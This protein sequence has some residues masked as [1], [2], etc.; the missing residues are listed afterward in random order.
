MTVLARRRWQASCRNFSASARLICASRTS[1]NLPTRTSSTPSKPRWESDR[2]MAFPWGSSTPFFSVTKM[3]AFTPYLL[4]CP[5]SQITWHSNTAASA[6]AALHSLTVLSKYASVARLAGA[7]HR[8]SRCSAYLR[9]GTLA[10]CPVEDRIDV[11]QVIPDVEQLVE[12]LPAEQR[13][14]LAVLPQQGG[15]LLVFPPCLHRGLLDDF[16]RPF[17]R[18][19][20]GGERQEHPLGIDEPA[21]A[22]EVLLH[23]VRIDQERLHHPPEPV[24]GEV[25]HDGGVRRDHPLRGRVTDVPLVPEG[26]V[27]HRGDGI[28]PQEPRQP[29]KVLRKHGVA[30]VRH[31][32]GSLLSRRKEFL[33]LQDL[34]PLKV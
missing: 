9:D 10:E 2:W 32:G 18:E 12:F 14:D 20:L 4:Q 3:R 26:D 33:D 27:F 29:G 31:R 6:P 30:L 16:I 13:P 23:P 21:R 17:P 11:F 7:A 34:R 8:R 22:L 24:E 15:K 5:V 19:S 1:M 25:E 28:P